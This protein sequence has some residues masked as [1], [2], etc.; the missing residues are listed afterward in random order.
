MKTRILPRRLPDRRGRLIAG[1]IPIPILILILVLVLGCGPASGSTYSEWQQRQPLDVPEPGLVRVDLSA[2]SLDA[3]QPGLDDLRLA[4][5]AGNEVPFVV[6]RPAPAPAPVRSPRSFTPALRGAS[7]VIEIETGFDVP[8]NAVTLETSDREWIKPVRLEGSRDGRRY[9]LIAD[10]IPLF[11]Q[12]VASDLTVHMPPADWA[13]LRLTLD[14]QRSPPAAFTGARLQAADPLDAP[15]QPV[16]VTV[17]S[18][19][20]SDS[21][22]RVLLDLGAANLT[23]AGV[24]I[25]T[26]E[27]LFQRGIE[28]R[29]SQA[30]GEEIRE[31]V[32]GRGLVFARALPGMATARKTAL[33]LDRQVPSREL[34]LLIHNLDSP[35]LVV[36]GIRASRR[37]VYV[38]FRSQVAGRHW[39]YSGNT[40]CPAARYDLGGLASDLKQGLTA[41]PGAMASNPE[42]HPAETLPGLAE[43][44]AALDTRPWRY[45]KKLSPAR[46][47]PQQ[48]ELDLDVLARAQPGLADLRLVQDG[49]QVP[50]L[51]EHPS[52]T[53]Q[54]T[55]GVAAANDPKRPQVSTWRITLP[56]SNL[57]L[58]RLECRA[59]TT[60]FQREMRL[61]EE[62]PDGRGGRLPVEL[63]RAEWRRA[64]D[65]NGAKD[66][67]LVMVLTR[68]PQSD[69]V[70]LETDNGDNPALG[71][72][73][74]RFSHP[75]TRLVFK[76]SGSPEL[77]YGNPTASAPRYDLALVAGP[78]LAAE[79][80]VTT[81][82]PE[83]RLRPEGWAGGE[84]LGGL[85]G[86][87]FWGILVLVVAGLIGV[88]VRLLPKP[89]AP[90]GGGGDR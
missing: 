86:W 43:T 59:Q 10:G 19:E 71:L 2:A 87:F 15:V 21:D 24:E 41:T 22:T 60:L 56:A 42:Y 1:A 85:R 73:R 82:G 75:V 83:E 66:A 72:E 68:A 13:W 33:A 37:P 9:V 49:R 45:R 4:D 70:F 3:L 55:P 32:V 48:L 36:S 79:R 8:I 26:P 25:E 52:L 62:L 11:R 53:R 88:I 77:Y 51:V 47:G 76:T 46:P 12:G 23:L 17:K 35:P 69:T 54:L 90:D 58:T 20:D 65:A 89:A 18:R 5:P 30:V 40:R 44:A 7:T 64:A 38:L 63:G 78:L 74:F 39:L 14:D 31:T 57:P 81:A 34:V 27:A 84:V 80:A 67:P 61:W 28:A 16:S 29:V 50:Y 6:Q